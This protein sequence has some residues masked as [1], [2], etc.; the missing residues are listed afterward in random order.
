MRAFLLVS[1]GVYTASDGIVRSNAKAINAMSENNFAY[2][3]L[4][5]EG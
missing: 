3:Y 5:L 2:K 4:N 1:L